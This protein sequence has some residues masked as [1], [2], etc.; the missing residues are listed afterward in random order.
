MPACAAALADGTQYVE[1]TFRA[2]GR[3]IDGQL[4]ADSVQLREPYASARK[5]EVVGR[6]RNLRPPRQ[7]FSVG[8]TVIEWNAHT[9]FEKIQPAALRDGMSIRVV[10]ELHDGVLV[11]SSLRLA[12]DLGPGVVRITGQATGVEEYGDGSRTL[13]LLEFPVRMLQPG[14]NAVESLTRRQDSRRPQAAPDRS[15]FGRP[16]AISTEFSLDLR[17]RRNLGLEREDFV[18]DAAS[19]FQLEMLYRPTARSYVYLGGKVLYEADVL[20]D[21]GNRDPVVAAERDQTWVYFERI[22]GSGFGL[23]LGRQNFKEKREWWW[24]DDLDAARVYYDRG[25]FHAEFALAREL[26]PVSTEDR[27]IDPEQRGVTRWIGTANWLWAPRHRLE[28][29]GLRAVDRSGTQQPGSLVDESLEDA[30]DS[31]LTWLGVRASGRR[32]VGAL[33][34]IDYWADAGWVR[35]SEV[36]TTYSDSTDGSRVDNVRR[37]RVDGSAFDIGVSWETGLPGSPALTVSHAQ[38]SG[39]DGDGDGVDRTFRQTG[40]HGNKWRYSGVNRFLVY[41]GALRPELSNIS[42]STIALGLPLLRNSSVELAWHRYRQVVPAPF[43]RNSRLDAEPNGIDPRLGD[44]LDL[45]IGLRE[46]RSID[47]ALTASAFRSGSAF[48]A[49]AGEIARLLLLEVTWSF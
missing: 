10:G 28:V 5:G 40:L 34:R 24:D 13:I 37:I 42:I 8:P 6:L 26:A 32:D 27:R 29:F 20:R 17:E 46:S 18:T 21:D 22:A 33:G 3:W 45:V 36:R 14:F 43:L 9:R 23:Q 15:L 2:T 39:D 44:G 35:G 16:L 19:E 12:D 11:A 47:V 7:R 48:G 4:V 1:R 30:E 49:D 41:G 38:G 31:S 25:P